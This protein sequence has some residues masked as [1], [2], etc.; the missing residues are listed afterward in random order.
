MVHRNTSHRR[1][2]EKTTKSRSRKEDRCHDS[3]Q[4]PPGDTPRN[5]VTLA[6]RIRCKG[7]FTRNI[8]TTIAQTKKTKSVVWQNKAKYYEDD[9]CPACKTM[10]DGT[11][12][13]LGQCASL[14]PL[15]E[16]GEKR[17]SEVTKRYRS[18][19]NA[20]NETW[21]SQLPNPRDDYTHYKGNQKRANWMGPE[22]LA[23]YHRAGGYISKDLANKIN[24][25]PKQQIEQEAWKISM[26]ALKTVKEMWDERNLK[27][28][29]MCE[30]IRRNN[31]NT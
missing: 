27:F 14:Q 20:N 16:T 29:E 11:L 2:Q 6:K 9:K 26:E 22:L 24:Q 13:V 25:R 8:G 5:L 21:E 12:H 30:E 15:K 18:T 31:R 3:R 1:C 7:L 17:L 10:V 4:K 23:K 28:E 19:P